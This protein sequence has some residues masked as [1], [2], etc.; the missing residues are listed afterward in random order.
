[1]V[2]DALE[3]KMLI[4]LYNWIVATGETLTS[5]PADVQVVPVV[6]VNSITAAPVTVA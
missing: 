1:M 6:D 3:T 5:W 4:L 2:T